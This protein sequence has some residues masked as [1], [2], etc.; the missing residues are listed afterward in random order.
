MN[1]TNITSKLFGGKQTTVKTNILKLDKNRTNGY[2]N[3]FLESCKSSHLRTKRQANP[4][5]VRI[6]QPSTQLMFM[7][8]INLSPTKQCPRRPLESS[9]K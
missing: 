5:D 2:L 8:R 6:I 4:I 7:L 1:M 9:I 3:I